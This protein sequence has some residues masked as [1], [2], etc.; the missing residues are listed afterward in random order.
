MKSL[1]SRIPPLARGLGIVA[2]VAGVVV[3][4][5]LEPVVATVGGLLQIVFFLAIAFFLFLLW[6]DRRGDLEAW[7][8][9][10]RRLFYAAIVL[11]VVDIG[12]LI[13]LGASGPDAFVFFVVLAACVWV[14]VRTWRLEHR[15]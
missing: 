12:M 5:S 4:L 13:G 2:L 9:R 15:Y 14:I 3:V 6:R 8:E 1:W 11:A 10:N 7:S